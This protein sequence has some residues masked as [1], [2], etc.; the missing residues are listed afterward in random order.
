[1]W[2]S[3]LILIENMGQDNP[4][5]FTAPDLL[6]T[7]LAIPSARTELVTRP[8][9]S[10]KLDTGLGQSLSLICAPAGFGKTTLL[11]NWIS[12]ETGRTLPLAWLS[13]DEDD[14]EP[15][16]FLSYLIC[17]LAK[18]VSI[19]AEELLALL[20]TAQPPP[21]KVILTALISRLETLPE[22]F[23]LALDDYHLI[24][25][26]PI[27]EALAFLLEHLPAQM[28]LILISREDPP[29]PL[30]RLRG[31]SELAEIRTDDLRFTSEEAGQFL[32]QM[33]GIALSTEQVRDLEE[34]TE[35]WIAGLQLAAL[36]MKG[37]E[38]VA[39]FIAAFTG[40]HRYILDYLTEEVLNRQPKQVQA[41][42]LE[43]SVLSRLCGPLCD[44]VTNRN[45]GQQMLERIERENLFLILLD[46]ERN[47]YRY[48]HL[49]SD[50]LRNR[51]RQTRGSSELE[52]LHRRASQWL[53]SAELI[54]ECVSH[55][56]AA[57]DFEFAANVL[58]E[59]GSRYF[60]ESWGNFGTKW[61]AQIPDTVMIQHPLLALNI[62]MWHGYLGRAA[63][64]QQYVDR[65]RTGLEGLSLPEAETD[66]LLGY[67]DT[68][69]ALSATINYDT[70]RA[71]KATERA[72][73]RL[74]ERQIRLRGTALLV[75][76]Y[77][78]Q[79][80]QRFDE[81]QV[82]Y[83][84]VIDIGQELSDLNLTT[85]AM[86]HNSEVALMQGHLRIAEVA[87]HSIIGL[88][89]D[90]KQEHMLNVGI[91]YGELGVIQLEQ[92]QLEAAAN[93]ALLCIERCDYVIPYY[94]LVGY[95]VLAR[96]YRLSGDMAACQQAAW[97][98]HDILENYPNV[99]ARIF[100][101]FVTHLWIK[102][103]LF[104][105]CRRF[106]ME[107]RKRA[108]SAFETEMLQLI[109]IGL[110]I[111]E[112]TDAA[113]TE[114]FSMLE[115]LRSILTKADSLTCW[116]DMLILE[117]LA[118]DAAQ[119]PDAAFDCL[120]EALEI[121]EP[122]GFV[123]IFVDRGDSMA[124][125]LRYSLRKS[126]HADYIETLL[127]AFDPTAEGYVATSESDYEALSEREIEVL[128][129]VAD[130]ASNREIAEQLFISIGTVKKHINN[131][132][133]KLDAHSRTQ[134]TAIAR[135]LNLL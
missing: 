17:A 40:S 27:H 91:V 134:A 8:R 55:A 41:F 33:L 128:L 95:A 50:M 73:Q 108:T 69:E 71:M 84:Q 24:T 102:D 56:V 6:R 45:D 44:A 131:M 90:A 36:A 126:W 16:R 31:R 64:A 4:V 118:L 125:L 121:A 42:L 10:E 22:R 12:S 38:D 111:E 104:A 35:G 113:L 77:V 129:L 1:M 63:L 96:V 19:E 105:D 82:I 62:G 97:H 67:A 106:L 117:S 109:A 9:L 101:L 15:G 60:V 107:Q 124:R 132:F 89:V 28:H 127:A 99:P 88:V 37:R 39:G 70:E 66:E 57:R 47:W 80:E 87:Y 2:R 92:N 26:R 34:R 93:S 58:E 72:L 110:L 85:R 116:L 135:D 20:Y 46:D 123:R 98:I 114:A 51:L 23:A 86:I 49:F 103:S 59:S 61:A 130:G 119:R 133:L 74:P 79:R 43:T 21:P 7:K 83:A 75:K 5:I 76:G 94:A 122:E 65:A 14:N 54:D 3:G 18:V 48:H 30:A 68:I 120:N 100:V 13:L 25:S 115:A 32:S 52:D 112:S 53:A 81:A 29:L 11:S 78:Y